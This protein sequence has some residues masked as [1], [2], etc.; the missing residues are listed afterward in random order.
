M[1]LTDR[2]TKLSSQ[3]EEVK[4]KRGDDD[5]AKVYEKLDLKITSYDEVKEIKSKRLFLEENEVYVKSLENDTIKMS[6]LAKKILERYELSPDH[7]SLTQGTTFDKVVEQLEKFNEIQKSSLKND[8]KEHC[9]GM[10]LEFSPESVQA[11]IP[12]TPDN[13]RSLKIWDTSYNSYLDISG[14]VPSDPVAI[15]RVQK[16]SEKLKEIYGQFNRDVPVEVTKFMNRV[17]DGTATLELLTPTVMQYLGEKALLNKYRVIPRNM[18]SS[19]QY[20]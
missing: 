13:E 1:T 9:K 2:L 17:K 15:E 20:G 10:F 5:A 12:N 8:W 3:L 16:A 18:T 4:A 14:E 7:K 11:E 6:T 19:S